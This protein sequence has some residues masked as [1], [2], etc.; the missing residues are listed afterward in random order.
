MD[1]GSCEDISNLL[2]ETLRV[3]SEHGRTMDDV[4]WIGCK[5]FRIPIERFLELA[6]D[7][8]YNSYGG[9]EVAADLMVVGDGWW[10]SRWEYDGS[11]GW[12]YNEPPKMP[13]EVRDVECLMFASADS[14]EKVNDPEYIEGNRPTGRF[15]VGVFDEY[16]KG[17]M[18][19]RKKE[20]YQYDRWWA[21]LKED[22]GNRSMI[23]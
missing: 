10:L 6:D 13:E 19:G 18:K 3:L 7:I 16:Y 23:E 20:M 1:H 12:E 15:Y 21:T 9:V 17:D 14:L 2:N 11:E 22:T 5:D 8:Y 4:L